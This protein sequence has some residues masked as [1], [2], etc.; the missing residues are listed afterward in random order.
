MSHVSVC[1]VVPTYNREHMVV[2]CINSLLNQSYPVAQIIVVNDGS[3]DN[4]AQVLS[5]F[6]EKITLVNK[7]NSGKAS[8]LN[9]GL[10]HCTSDWVWICDDDDIADA[11]GLEKLINCLGDHSDAQVILGGYE[12]FFDTPTG[13]Q[14]EAPAYKKRSN[15]SNYSVAFMEGMFTLQFAMLVKKAVYDAVGTFNERLVRSQDY[16]MTLRIMRRFPAIETD[17]IIFYQRQHAGQ[18][19]SGTENFSSG[20]SEEKWLKYDRHIFE[21][22]CSDYDLL[23]FRPSYCM[24]AEIIQQRTAALVEKACVLA[25]RAMWSEAIDDLQTA[26]G[27]SPQSLLP[28]ALKISEQ[29]I[30]NDLPWTILMQRRD[31][32]QRLAHARRSSQSGDMIVSAMFRPVVWQIKKSFVNK[33]WRDSLRLAGLMLSVLGPYGSIKRVV[34]SILK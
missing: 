6:D 5:A 16:E 17:E 1:A 27:S 14:Y 26:A 15:E 10:K 33:K 28:E 4:T 2:D 13:R 34:L 12:I 20:Q 25:K 7:R 21:E 23:E 32:Q 31:W 9:I 24:D 3:T 30:S 19:G 22:I 8:A 11:D 29:F 18:R